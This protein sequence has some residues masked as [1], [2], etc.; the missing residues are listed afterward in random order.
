MTEF[1]PSSHVVSC[2]VSELV[3]LLPALSQILRLP[4]QPPFPHEEKR[5]RLVALSR[6]PAAPFMSPA[7]FYVGPVSAL[8]D[9]PYGYC[10]SRSRPPVSRRGLAAGVRLYRQA[11]PWFCGTLSARR[12]A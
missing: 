1:K 10:A 12:L 9:E 3:F 4:E 11:G 2:P 8:D 5:L 7:P 6:V